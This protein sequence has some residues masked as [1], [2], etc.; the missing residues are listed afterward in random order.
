LCVCGDIS[1]R[2]GKIL[3]DDLNGQIVSGFTA[4]MGPSGSGKSTLLNTLACRMGQSASIAGRILLNGRDYK[5]AD[6]KK[7]SGYVMQDDLLNAH[8]TVEETL[9]YTTRLKLE[10]SLTEEEVNTRVDEIVKQMGLDHVRNTVIGSPEK[11][12]ISGGERKRVCVGMELLTHPQLLFL[13]EPTSGML[14]APN[15]NLKHPWS[16][17]TVFQSFS[18]NANV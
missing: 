16:F 1:C 14:L 11:R 17:P 18:R 6:L 15:D 5:I 13:D 8:L 7:M 3:L 10:P 9:K 2:V 4:I 12:G